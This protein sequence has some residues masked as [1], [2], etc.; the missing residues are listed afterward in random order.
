MIPMKLTRLEVWKNDG[1]SDSESGYFFSFH[2]KF[3][4]SYVTVLLRMKGLSFF[5]ILYCLSEFNSSLNYRGIML[6]NALHVKVSIL[7]L[8]FET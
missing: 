1:H 2:K 6:C 4:N 7:E 5:G 8:Q 3:H